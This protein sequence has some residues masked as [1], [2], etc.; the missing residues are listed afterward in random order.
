MLVILFDA[1]NSGNTV[2]AEHRRSKRPDIWIPRSG[3]L[4]QA[5]LRAERLAQRQFILH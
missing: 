4:E 2:G 5:S 1:D 3:P